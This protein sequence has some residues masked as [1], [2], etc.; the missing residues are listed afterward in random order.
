MLMEIL[1]FMDAAWV[2][3]GVYFSVFYCLYNFEE[4]RMDALDEYLGV[5]R[6]SGPDIKNTK[7]LVMIGEIIEKRRRRRTLRIRERFRH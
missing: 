2:R 6:D 4:G 7:V 5:E 1:F 3:E